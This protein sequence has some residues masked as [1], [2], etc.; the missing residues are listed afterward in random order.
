MERTLSAEEKIRRAEEIYERR[1]G[2]YN[3]HNVA[4]VSVS[5]KKNY[6][7]FKKMIL[8]ILICLLIYFIFYLILY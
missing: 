3:T 6:N 5:E 4:T 2:G 8:Q 1:R 7:L